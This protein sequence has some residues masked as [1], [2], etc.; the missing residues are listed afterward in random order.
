MFCFTI[1][2]WVKTIA[3]AL[4]IVLL[5]LLLV[6]INSRSDQPNSQWRS[7]RRGLEHIDSEMKKR[8]EAMQELKR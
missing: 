4:T 5:A 2:D 1:T 8:D 6:A 7:L 3:I